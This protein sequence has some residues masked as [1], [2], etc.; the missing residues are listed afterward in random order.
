M[1]TTVTITGTGCPIPSA[2]RSGPGVLV[3]TND[4][5]LQFDAGR[6]TTQRL[7]SCELWP[8]D[9]DA[10]FATHHHSDHLVGFADLLL[11]RWVM[12][13]TDSISDLPV[14]VP[15]GPA[16]K[17]VNH[18]L[19]AWLDDIAV[20]KSHSKRSTEPGTEIFPF[21]ATNNLEEV[22]SRGDTKVSACRV[23]HEPVFPAVGYR[24]ES[25]DG[26][27]A[28][29]GDTLVCDEVITLATGADVLVYEAMRFEEI[30]ALP[31]KRQFILDYHADTRLIGTQAQEIGIKTLI[32]THLIPE[33][34][35]Q[36]DEQ[37]FIDDIREGGFTGELIVA[38]DLDSVTLE[39]NLT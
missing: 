28:I 1:P 35:S 24:I 36:E 34:C 37:A 31:E 29:T 8:T 38:N 9:L 6:G 16:E 14:I 11:T 23:R 2:H 3:Q 7:A 30:Q 20:R 21:A 4:V 5:A 32:L 25:S 39:N 17:F 27:V 10:F 13:R 12:D 15:E 26:V 19:D 22:W 18:V 33:P